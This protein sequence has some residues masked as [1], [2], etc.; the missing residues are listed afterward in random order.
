MTHMTIRYQDGREDRGVIIVPNMPSGF[1]LDYV[2]QNID[3][4]PIVLN[5]EDYGKMETL[6][7]SGIGLNV[8]QD[9][10]KVEWYR[11]E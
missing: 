1:S 10:V 7:F 4:V 11:Y 5:T 9:S 3:D 8:L 2:P 6:E